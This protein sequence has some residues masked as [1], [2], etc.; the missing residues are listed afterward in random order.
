[1]GDVFII[2]DCCAAGSLG[3][4]IGARGRWARRAFEFL[5]A[6]SAGDTTQE[7]GPSSFTSGLVWALDQLVKADGFLVSDLLRKITSAPQF[8]PNQ[9]PVHYDRD[10]PSLKKIFISPLLKDGSRQKEAVAKQPTVLAERMEFL[11]L[12]VQLSHHPTEDD[13]A[14][15]AKTLKQ[16]IKTNSMPAVQHIAWG[17]LSAIEGS[18][19]RF[20]TLARSLSAFQKLGRK[21][22]NKG[23]TQNTLQ[24]SKNLNND[25]VFGDP[26]LEL[27]DAPGPNRKRRRRR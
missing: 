21:A 12:R 4:D 5:G 15:I 27:P 24:A 13:I 20:G 23:L 19:R 9:Y 1:L 16:D 7:P 6:T 26:S 18:T 22:R 10:K 3:R 25:D 8:P 2:F 14:N 17:K 11:D